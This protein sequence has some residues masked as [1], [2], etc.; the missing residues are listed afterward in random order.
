MTGLEVLDTVGGLRRKAPGGHRGGCGCAADSAR[1]R[2][3]GLPV[4]GSR[5]SVP[6]TTRQRARVPVRERRAVPESGVTIRPRYDLTSPQYRQP[7][8][9][10]LGTTFFHSEYWS[11]GGL[12]NVSALSHRVSPSIRSQN[13]KKC[14]QVSSEPVLCLEPPHDPRAAIAAASGARGDLSDASIAEI[15]RSGSRQA[16][17]AVYDRFSGLVNRWVWRLLGADPEHD[18]IVQQVFIRIL[19]SGPNLRDSDK[20]VAW[21]HSITI[22]TVHSELRRRQVRR[23]FW[24]EIPPAVLHGDFVREVE[25]RDLLVR[26]KSVIDKLPP[27]ERIAFMLHYV[28]RHSALEIAELCGYS[29]STAK[30]RLASA[31]RRFEAIVAASPDLSRVLPRLT[32]EEP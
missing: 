3:S 5:T 14:C 17:T 6:E 4:A 8:T 15:L 16:A 20:L 27:A 7:K 10:S 30:R 13:P 23:L 26:A 9:F 24:R 11:S 29:L 22:N 1:R 19:R 32:A 21:V 31:A 2:A 12:S 18:D 25:V 28:D